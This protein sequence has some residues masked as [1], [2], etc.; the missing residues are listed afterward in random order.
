MV[1]P[2]IDSYG[3]GWVGTHTTA[4]VIWASQMRVSLI[5][6]ALRQGR[7]VVVVSGPGS[8]M[9][10]PM[11]DLL[12]CAGGRWVVRADNNTLYDAWS[13]RQL[14]DVNAAF[15]NP[16]RMPF[17]EP[18]TRTSHPAVVQL[19][20]SWSVRH[21]PDSDTMIGAFAE[22]FLAA[23]G[24]GAPIG[25]GPCEPVSESWNPVAVTRFVHTRLAAE[26][27][28]APYQPEVRLVVTAAGEHPAV[29]VMTVRKTRRGLEE[30]VTGLI[31]AGPWQSPVSDARMNSVRTRLADLSDSMPLFALVAAQGGPHDL[32]L[33]PHRSSRPLPLAML[34]GPPGV[35][36]LQIDVA[37]MRR[38]GAEQVGRRRQSGLLFPFSPAWAQSGQPGQ[39]AR[40]DQIVAAIGADGLRLM[41]GRAGD[42]LTSPEQ[43]HAT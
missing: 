9:T 39:R 13:G 29:L 25:W 6:L 1:H 36:E 24:T 17:A 15:S 14:T 40:P 26:D 11:R 27:G 5:E 35:Y 41:M 18:W 30:L 37:F 32:T 3:T 43:P 4:P 33:P 42:Q 31:A 16:Y 2:L 20:V 38:L 7:R 8:R 23:I 10:E 21:A 12:A 22:T 28:I 19:V 34:I